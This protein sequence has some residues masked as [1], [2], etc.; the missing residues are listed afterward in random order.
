L[1]HEEWFAADGVTLLNTITSSYDAASQ[2]TGIADTYSNYTYTYDGIGRV[3]E[4]DNTGTPGVPVVILTSAYDAM[5]RISLAADLG[6]TLDFFNSYT[7]DALG[8]LTR[9]EQ[10]GQLGGNGV[11]D[12]RVDLSYNAVGQFTTI[13]RYEDLAGTQLVATSNYSYDNAG[14]LTGLSHTKGANTL[15]DYTWSYDAGARVTQFTSPDGTT[16]YTYDNTDQL[17]LA[18]HTY[19]TDESYL[20]DD[21]GN[22]TNT[23]YV[24]GFNNQ[25][26]SDGTYDYEY[27]AEG[28]RTKKTEIASGDYVDYDWDHHN[29]LVSVAFYSSAGVLTKEVRYTYDVYD[30][31][32]R[33]EVDD[34]GNGVIDRA[35]SFVYDGDDVVL[36]FDGAGSLTHRYLHGDATDQ[37]FADDSF[38]EILWALDD[39][40]G[41]VRDVLNYDP[42]TDTSSVFNHRQFDGFG[43]I[44]AE[45]NGAIEFRYAYTGEYFDEDTGLQYHWY[46]WY[47]PGVG[48]W[49]SEDPIGI[50]G[51]DPNFSRYVENSPT[52][53]T[54]PNGL[55]K[56]QGRTVRRRHWR[57]PPS[58]TRT[59]GTTPPQPPPGP[60]RTW[61]EYDFHHRPRRLNNGR[62]YP[63]VEEQALRSLRETRRAMR[64][65]RM[66]ISAAETYAR[67]AGVP[68]SEIRAIVNQRFITR[69]GSRFDYTRA[70]SQQLQRAAERARAACG[71]QVTTPA[72]SPLLARYLR[73]SGGRWGGT[74]VRQ[75][76]HQ[77]ATALEQGGFRVTHGAGRGS[78]EWIRGTGPGATGG[79]WV[80][81]RATN[82]TRTIRI[83]TITTQADGFT[84]I[85]SEAA[86]AARIRAKFPNDEL[87]VIP[88]PR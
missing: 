57:R 58:E 65:A 62:Q 52:N 87:W 11:P 10:S 55:S 39:N 53:Y 74:A 51:G 78:E 73:E 5:Y 17:T 18:D 47:D 12:K 20:Y 60:Y 85:P 13:E 14:R 28:N 80:D 34:T 63:P 61:S 48:R 41:S 86:A 67:R 43:K 23:G 46:R 26:L 88:K 24:T 42:T 32:I 22:R 2:L 16:D 21:N 30:R 44:T 72:N 66:T 3:T 33:K 68:E 49:V 7:W 83:Q 76:N 1:T 8:R 69:P 56:G 27:D 79:T 15:A 71:G 45:T 59:G 4:V 38:V 50:D 81:I 40:Q 82:G 36:S 31:L 6:G 77:L 84:P 64:E 29:R 19:Q 9:L 75:L 35:E 54:D 25:L 70:I 37:V